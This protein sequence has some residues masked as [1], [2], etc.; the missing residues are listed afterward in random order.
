MFRKKRFWILTIYAALLAAS[1]AVRNSRE[2]EP[3]S[4]ERKFQSVS[5]E[6]NRPAKIAYKE[7]GEVGDNEIP[8]VMIHG[9]P[10]SAGAFDGLASALPGR[11]IFSIDLPGF[12]FSERNVPDYSIEAHARYVNALLKAKGVEKAHFVGFSLGG[13]VVMHSAEFN[14]ELVESVTFIA[15]IGVQEY[16]LFGGFYVNRAIH[17]G[18]LALAW[19]LRELTPHFGLFDGGMVQYS[20]NF[21][22]TDQRPLRRMLASVEKPFLILHGKDDPLVPVEAAREHARIVPQSEYHELDDNHFFVFMRPGTVSG[23]L[24][25]FWRRVEKGKAVTRSTADENRII[26]A[27]RPFE[28]K[29]IRAMGPALFCFFLLFL[30]VAL[31]NADLAAV[32]AAVFA[33]Q[34]RFG[35]VIPIVAICFGV[36]L[37][38]LVWRRIGKNRESAKKQGEWTERFG[39]HFVLFFR[40][41]SKAFG[42]FLFNLG[43]VIPKAIGLGAFAYVIL[44]GLL[45]LGV[46]ATTNTFVF[47]GI[48]IS[49]FV[50]KGIAIRWLPWLD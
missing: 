27:T 20:R 29:I 23:K 15:S 33:A 34:G 8:V 21:Y 48:G 37:S 26:A 11:K 16:E 50:L 44:Q 17:A 31:F 45:F 46:L 40:E 30:A 12:G 32:L 6:D 18:Q 1:Y 47:L 49:V 9:S 3:I 43:V 24:D 25:D 28:Y 10:G 19:M 2:P 4:A 41:G 13:G 36:L 7:F 22:D 35:L 38:G 14:P 39:F 5:V 42:K